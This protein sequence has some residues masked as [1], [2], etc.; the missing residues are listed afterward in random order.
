MSPWDYALTQTGAIV[1]YLRLAVWPHPLAADYDGWPIATSLMSMLPYVALLTLLAG[2]TVWGLVRWRPLAF[3]GIWFFAI[4]AP[5]SS[6][7][8]LAAEVVAE[9]RMYLPLVAVVVLAV[10][11]GWGLLVRLKAPRVVGI[12]GVAVIAAILGIVTVQRNRT[13]RTTL[14]FWND[15]VAKRPDNPRARIWLAKHLREEGR[16]PEAIEHLTVAVRL[17]PGN[18]DAQYGLGVA[19]A[20]QGRTDEA[21]EHYREALRIN[22]EDASAHN[23]LGA[24]LAGRGQIVDAI[25]HYLEAIRINPAYAGPHYNL[26]LVLADLGEV[27]EAILHLEAAVGID[28]NFTAARQALEALRRRETGQ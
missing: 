28:P 16:N 4:L 2:L 8:P 22:P 20:S 23:N 10:L 26:A 27:H 7:R 17:Q 25:R 5:T 9:R 13:Y 12:A 11:G 14:S 24:A 18:G 19:L 15:V 3:L 1:H 21:I 6:V